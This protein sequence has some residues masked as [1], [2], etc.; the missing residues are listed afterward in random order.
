[1][2]RAFDIASLN[3]TVIGAARSGLAAARFLHHKGVS[4]FL[5]ELSPAAKYEDAARLLAADGIPHEFGQHSARVFAADLMV[6]SPGVPSDAPIIERPNAG[7]C[8]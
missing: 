1:M 5:T 4:V 8:R 2:Q 3:V 7:D 6:V